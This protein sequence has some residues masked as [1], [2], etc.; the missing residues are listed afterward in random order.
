MGVCPCFEW[1]E[2]EEGG[3]P[4]SMSWER[5]NRCSRGGEGRQDEG[6]KKGRNRGK[7]SGGSELDTGI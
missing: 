3:Q 4:G 6:G 2:G 1:V 7:H 5:Q